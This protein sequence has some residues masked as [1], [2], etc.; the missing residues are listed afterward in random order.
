MVGLGLAVALQVKVAESGSV[1]VSW[2]GSRLLLLE[3]LH[4]KSKHVEHQKPMMTGTYNIMD[5]HVHIYAPYFC[6]QIYVV[7]VDYTNLER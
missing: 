4:E 5:I 7:T 3:Q 1:T 6:Q 2:R